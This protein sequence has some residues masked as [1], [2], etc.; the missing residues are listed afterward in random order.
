MDNSSNK[1]NIGE[2]SMEKMFDNIGINMGEIK[3]NSPA[4]KINIT[5]ENNNKLFLVGA[6][7][8]CME[9]K[10]IKYDLSDIN[11][12]TI[13]SID[14]HHELEC[15]VI[16][17]GAI[18]TVYNAKNANIDELDINNI[19]KNILLNIGC[20]IL[21]YDDLK[22]MAE[23]IISNTFEEAIGVDSILKKLKSRIIKIW[24]L[25]YGEIDNIK[26][27]LEKE[28]MDINKK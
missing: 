15:I 14:K 13:I 27:N 12:Y 5:S 23:N 4:I 21:Y 19:V 18:T 28:L 3:L 17:I 20:G 22:N 8:L 1:I 9:D 24:F 7:L 6:Q 2:F 10:D 11:D 16:I 26:N 25:P